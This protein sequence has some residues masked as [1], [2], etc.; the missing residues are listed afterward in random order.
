MNRHT[1]VTIYFV[2]ISPTGYNSLVRFAI[3]GIIDKTQL[4]QLS[5]PSLR[6]R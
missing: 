5:L 1:I 2:R 3:T 4:S 6:D